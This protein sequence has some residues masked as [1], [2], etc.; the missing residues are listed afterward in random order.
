MSVPLT[1]TEIGASITA[2]ASVA[3]GSTFEIAWDGPDYDGDYVGIGRVGASGSARWETFVYT[4]EGTPAMIQAPAGPGDYEIT[5]FQ[6]QDR[7]PLV[8]VPL[9]VR[10]ENASLVAPSEAGA[11]SRIEV[12]WDGPGNAGDFIG[13]GR[14][15]AE[16]GARW[17]TYAEVAA[18]SP[19]QVQVP[20]QPG[21]YVIR[22]F[23]GQGYTPVAEVPL[24]VKPVDADLTAPD[25]AAAGS[26]IEVGWTEPG[27]AG[28]YLG[29]GLADADGAGQWQVWAYADSG[30]PLRMTLPAE[31]GQYVIRYFL[32][33]GA[34]AV[35]ERPLVVE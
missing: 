13:I 33:Q 5:Y 1:V 17:E 25:R 32:G 31:P 9:T 14:V 7:T 18:G 19:V 20:A 23:L 3:A 26:E 34:V 15:G 35:V 21:E 2:P 29:I 4:R 27:N 12:T 22:Y 10:E 11:G 8:S 6:R 16:G 24:S 30:N 28:D